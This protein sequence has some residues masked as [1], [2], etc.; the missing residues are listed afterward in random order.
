MVVG[1]LFL[2]EN[3]K[4]IDPEPTGFPN[5]ISVILLVVGSWNDFES[6]VQAFYHAS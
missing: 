6:W 3:A 4:V 2:P 5:K 1:I